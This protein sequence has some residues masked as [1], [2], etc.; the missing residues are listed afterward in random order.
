[1]NFAEAPLYEQ[2]LGIL[3]KPLVQVKCYMNNETLFRWSINAPTINL[4]RF[5]GCA[6]LGSGLVAGRESEMLLEESA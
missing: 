6:I 1:V 5:V 3:C 2:H 4:C